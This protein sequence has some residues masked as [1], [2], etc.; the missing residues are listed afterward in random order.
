MK[1]GKSVGYHG[2]S[3]EM[4]K[5]AVTK[6]NQRLVN[7]MTILF[8]KIIETSKVSDDFNVSIIKPLIKD[9]TKPSDT[10]AN[11][12]PVATSDVTPNIWEKV[13]L[14]KVREQCKTH[15]KQF[16]F[17]K[18]SSCAHA[19]FFLKQ[20][21]KLARM[22]K[23]RVYMC[24]LD[25]SK[26]FDK[27]IRLILWWKLA[28]KGLCVMLLKGLMAYYN[29]SKI[30]VSLNGEQSGKIPSTVGNKQ[31]GPISPEFYDQYGDEKKKKKKRAIP[32]I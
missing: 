11:L 15:D 25:A 24:A 8:N 7:F 17:K 30:I 21:I 23:K 12:R 9:N 20:T 10:K 29:A 28:K 18:R 14:I 26:A 4:V 6:K 3:N 13:T 31:G 16:G 19:V 27:V 2:I 5:Y 32:I 1:N 22:A